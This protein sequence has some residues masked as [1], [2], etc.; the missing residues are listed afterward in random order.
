MIR[1]QN[2]KMASRKST[3]F[4]KITAIGALLLAPSLG[5]TQFAMAAPV[6]VRFFEGATR[7][8][9]L[10]HT[11]EGVFLGRGDLIQVVRGGEV[12]NRMVFR[13]EDGSVFDETVVFAQQRFFTLERYS[14]VQRGPA[15]KEDVE[16]SMERTGKYRVKTKPHGEGKEKVFEGTLDLPPDVYNGLV[17]TIVKNL[18]KG[19]S[20][21]IHLVAFTPAPRLIQLELAPAG[22]HKV[23]VGGVA[24]TA[25]RYVLRPKLGVWL[26]LFAR[27]L[28]RLPPDSNAW[29]IHDEV[30]AFVRFEGQL[31][32][33]GPVWRVEL[34]VPRLPDKPESSAEK[35]G[36]VK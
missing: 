26:E 21:T 30:P 27:L 2:F 12:D 19:A 35:P 7:A 20:E 8:F 6:P 17:L 16:V 11:V 1:Q 31:S 14:L 36:F 10:I 4:I 3:L 15:F 32:P 23:L 33:T 25:V 9:L 28:G 29:I 22:E 24:R 18:P 5:W 13:F 34:T